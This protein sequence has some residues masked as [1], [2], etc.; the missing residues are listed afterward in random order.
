[1]PKPLPHLGGDLFVPLGRTLARRQQPQMHELLDDA[2][3]RVALIDGGT[4][5]HELL[6]PGWSP[7]A[8]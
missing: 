8:G 2:E 4:D 3:R 5:V 7:P 6:R 1:M